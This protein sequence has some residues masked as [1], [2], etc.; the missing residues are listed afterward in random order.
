MDKTVKNCCALKNNQYRGGAD[1]PVYLFRDR[2]FDPYL[3][4]SRAGLIL[5]VD[6]RHD[7]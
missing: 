2:I 7:P 5:F 6:S 1:T 3:Q 4:C